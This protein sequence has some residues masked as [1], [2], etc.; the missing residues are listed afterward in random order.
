M[1]IEAVYMFCELLFQR[2]KTDTWKQLM[3]ELHEARDPHMVRVLIS[4]RILDHKL[5]KNL[6]NNSQCLMCNITVYV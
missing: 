3:K 1:Q 2:K 5:I 6:R 4:H